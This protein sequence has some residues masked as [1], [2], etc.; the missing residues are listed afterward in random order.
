MLSI[1]NN[2]EKQ[3]ENLPFGKIN[4]FPKPSFF[5]QEKLTTF[6]LKTEKS[7]GLWGA[8]VGICIVFSSAYSFLQEAGVDNF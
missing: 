2:N 7:G 1:E 3:K 6:F 5:L 4:N 8:E